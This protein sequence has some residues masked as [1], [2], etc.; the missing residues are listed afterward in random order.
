M[1]HFIYR[2][3]LS[4]FLSLL[5]LV[6]NT[7]NS[8]AS[9]TGHNVVLD[10]DSPLSGYITFSKGVYYYCNLAGTSD[11]SYYMNGS[12]F[13]CTFDTP[14]DGPT[15]YFG[16]SYRISYQILKK[17]GISWTTVATY[18][19]ISYGTP[20]SSSSTIGAY[21]ISTEGNYRFVATA[22]YKEIGATTWANIGSAY[23]EVTIKLGT[24]PEA[25]FKINNATYVSA[26]IKSV[27]LCAGVD[28]LWAPPIL[29]SSLPAAFNNKH[30][31]EI[32]ESTATGTTGTPTL[33]TTTYTV[34]L[35]STTV[36]NAIPS[37]A[38]GTIPAAGAYR[39]VKLFIKNDCSEKVFSYLINVLPS[40]PTSALIN[41]NFYASYDADLLEGTDI[42]TDNTIAASTTC[43]APA[44]V[45]G[46]SIGLTGMSVSNLSGAL[47]WYRLR[48][49][50]GNSSTICG[51]T[52]PL[53][54]D[55]TVTT[56]IIP[57]QILFNTLGIGGV[58]PTNYFNN[59]V[60]AGTHV[61]RRWKVD[62]TIGIA[63]CA[64]T[65]LSRI[66]YF[67][68]TNAFRLAAVAAD[69]ILPVDFDI[70][71]NPVDATLNLKFSIADAQA[72]SIK[73]L[74]TNGQVV[75]NI[76]DN[77]LLGEGEYKQSTSG[78]VD[79]P[80]GIYYVQYQD[81]NKTETKKFF[82]K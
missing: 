74:N 58:A 12:A 71:P 38:F 47:D 51:T 43:S 27:Y 35:P 65:T 3:L 53:I 68:I 72:V 33:T 52:I 26:P 30:K 32:Y 17:I 81:A 66:T 60:T 48:I 70:Y 75:M 69:E 28:W 79:L 78:I 67:K 59:L 55:N 5:L 50:E 77:Q 41:Y 39:L 20:Y 80:A 56:T 61:G 1:K 13:S 63:G 24:P 44:A 10:V 9:C 16:G 22:Q 4:T 23:E 8:S 19:T 37:S 34:G 14:G 62:F 18:N 25:T 29:A 73:V 42:S 11:L 64:S 2:Y 6:T 36:A 21:T 76:L 46:Y 82:K 31:L 7:N 40:N 45:G 54:Y 15:P 57:Y 49:Y